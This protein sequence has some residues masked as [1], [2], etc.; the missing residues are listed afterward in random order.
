MAFLGKKLKNLQTELKEH[1]T[2]ASEGNQK[3]IDPN[4]KGRQ[5]ARRFY[6][7]CRNNGHN[8][9]DCR[10][11]IRDEEV[12][13]LQNEATAEKKVTFTQDYNK[14]RG[15]SYG[16]GNWTG[17]ND[18]NAAMM[19]TPQPDTRGKFR[20][21]TQSFNNFNRNR[22]FERRDYSSKKNDRYNEYKARSP[23]QP[24]EDHSRN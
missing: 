3:P 19:S 2:N 14:R 20:P 18:D 12:K 17:Q 9:N 5:N 21:G 23:Y 1:R 6:G 24:N 15:P 10:K 16:S 8:P 4:Q 22:P 13:K 11:K 7:F